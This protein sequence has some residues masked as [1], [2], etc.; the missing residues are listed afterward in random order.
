MAF[1]DTQ[2]APMDAA[3]GDDPFAQFRS[4]HPREVMALLREVRDSATP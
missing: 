2:P 3:D 1:L 4:S